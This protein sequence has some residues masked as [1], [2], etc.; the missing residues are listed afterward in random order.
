MLVK[1]LRSS[2]RP[3][4]LFVRRPSSTNPLV[5]SPAAGRAADAAI[6]KG[7]VESAAGQQQQWL[8][9]GGDPPF[10]SG[11]VAVAVGEGASAF[12]RLLPTSPV[13]VLGQTWPAPEGSG[14]RRSCLFCAFSMWTSQ[15]DKSL[16]LLK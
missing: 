12:A 8:T 3:P 5:R 10:P 11:R 6:V 16:T 14:M 9:K 15:G 13:A 7:R 2:S 4:R 1:A